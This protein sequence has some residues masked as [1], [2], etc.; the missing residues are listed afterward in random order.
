M[1][2]RH[3]MGIER[4]I[5]LFAEHGQFEWSL[6]RQ[7]CDED[8]PIRA[9]EGVL[10]AALSD[11][12]RRLLGIYGWTWGGAREGDG[13]LPRTLIDPSR[14]GT[15]WTEEQVKVLTRCKPRNQAW[16]WRES[17][18]TWLPGMELAP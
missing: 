10:A 13:N 1:N 11:E 3:A 18:F 2:D 7:D 9:G 8:A 16:E 6:M 15:G 17:D 12:E 5:R 14:S 4:G